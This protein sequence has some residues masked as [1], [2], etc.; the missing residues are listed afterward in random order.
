MSVPVKCIATSSWT[1]Q[2]IAMMFW[3]RDHLLSSLFMVITVSCSPFPLADDSSDG[4]SLAKLKSIYSS[5]PPSLAKVNAAIFQNTDQPIS[6]WPSLNPSSI[7]VDSQE[8]IYDST[9]QIAI[10]GS[11][12]Q[13]KVLHIDRA[14]AEMHQLV[15]DAT[16]TLL[17]NPLSD[18]NRLYWG[19][20]NS[21]DLSTPVGV[22]GQVLFGN[23]DDI[24]ISCEDPQN[25]CG[26][27][28]ISEVGG[29]VNEA[30]GSIH[31]CS[32]VFER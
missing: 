5:G 3:L 23:K 27:E 15:F 10:D 24:S 7:D 25:R 28:F 8:P 19:P 22:F 2:C 12:D 21:T 32:S 16:S 29:Y 20:S 6:I 1:R 18:M 11:C 26:D 4:V 17:Q 14:L 13:S 9:F 30:T 31:L